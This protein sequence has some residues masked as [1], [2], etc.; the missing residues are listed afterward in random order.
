MNS[1]KNR[2]NR[3]ETFSQNFIRILGEKDYYHFCECMGATDFENADVVDTM[4]DF[5]FE[6]NMTNQIMYK[7]LW[8]NLMK[9]TLQYLSSFPNFHILVDT[10]VLK[11]VE[12]QKMIVCCTYFHCRRYNQVI[13]T[14]PRPSWD[15]VRPLIQNPKF[16]E[17]LRQVQC[18]PFIR[19]YAKPKSYDQAHAKYPITTY[20]PYRNP[21]QKIIPIANGKIYMLSYADNEHAL[22]TVRNRFHKGYFQKWTAGLEWKSFRVFFHKCGTHY[23]TP[24][25]NR[26]FR[27]REAMLNYASHPYPGIYMA[28]EGLSRNQGW[29]EGALE[30]VQRVLKHLIEKNENS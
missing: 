18:Q 13:W 28:S 8:N 2:W 22:E 24:F 12:R 16:N 15:L 7:V 4:Q 19:V 20:L 11:V 10:P 25:P 17:I 21:L 26:Y 3:Q 5:G 23:F 30:S 1:N 27:N 6:D 14:A 29:T 9:A